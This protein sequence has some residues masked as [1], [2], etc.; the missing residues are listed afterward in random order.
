MCQPG[1]SAEPSEARRPWE[2]RLT[3]EA[4]KER[5]KQEDIS[6]LQCFLQYPADPG[7]RTSLRSVLAPGCH[8]PRLWRLVS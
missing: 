2:T 7:G 5:N 1:A 8:I 4:L 6:H 3:G